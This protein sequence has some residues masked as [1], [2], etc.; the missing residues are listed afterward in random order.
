MRG[1][2]NHDM[3][4]IENTTSLDILLPFRG[5]TISPAATFDALRPSTVMTRTNN[6]TAAINVPVPKP[7]ISRTRAVNNAPKCL[8]QDLEDLAKKMQGRLGGIDAKVEN[9]RNVLSTIC[10]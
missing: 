6:R 1:S 8:E 3:S 10:R 7:P 4:R 2:S 5:P 9:R